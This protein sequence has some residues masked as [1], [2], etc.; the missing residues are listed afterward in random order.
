MLCHVPH[1]VW[2]FAID[3]YYFTHWDM[4]GPVLVS[5][6]IAYASTSQTVCREAYFSFFFFLNQSYYAAHMTYNS[7]HKFEPT[8]CVYL[9]QKESLPITHLY[10][11]IMSN[12]INILSAYSQFLYLFHMDP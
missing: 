10:V 3:I 2:T 11:V 9:L 12:A 6:W 7:V 1:P 8:N 5:L 4:P